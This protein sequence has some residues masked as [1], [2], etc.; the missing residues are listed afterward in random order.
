MEWNRY[1][2]ELSLFIARDKQDVVALA[3]KGEVLS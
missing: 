1:L 3:Q 2:K